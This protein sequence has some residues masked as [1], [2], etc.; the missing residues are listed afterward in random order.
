MTP[1]ELRIGAFPPLI[2]PAPAPERLAAFACAAAD[3]G[4]DHIA[5]GDHVSFRIGAGADALV[6]ATAIAM[7][8]PSIPVYVGVYLL[9]LRH[10]VVVARQVA[11]LELLAPG[12]L[13]L[14]IGVGGEDPNE[15]AMCGV[16]HRTRGRRTDESIA[17][18]RALLSGERVTHRGE[19]F[20]I[21]EAVVSPAP[22]TR[23]PLPIGGRSD[24]AL[25][26]AALLGDGWLGIW[27]SARR[28]E[29]AVASIDEQ[30]VAAGRRGYPR[31][32]AMQVWC[33]IADDRWHARALLAE[34][35]ERFYQMPFERFERYS[36]YGTPQDIADFLGPYVDAGCGTFNLIPQSPN[37]TT[38]VEGAAEVKR[39]LMKTTAAHA[40]VG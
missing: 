1:V 6:S 20:D 9:S 34:Q 22:Q 23:V 28:F 2:G 37:I 12:R 31:E 36:P 19:F 21:A 29:E 17:L 24:A 8:H 30:A 7:S 33:G 25:R 14:G 5:V 4:L 32:H 26:R 13:V 35:M 38:A 40:V 3:A 15:F 39:L 11:D 16:D 18:L 27:V 10:P